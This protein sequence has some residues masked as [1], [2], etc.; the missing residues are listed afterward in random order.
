MG[1]DIAC[2]ASPV[3]GIDQR[4]QIRPQGA[5]CDIGAVESALA[6]PVLLFVYLP[7]LIK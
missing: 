7:L 5:H 6:S 3:L 2:V 1:S 4:G